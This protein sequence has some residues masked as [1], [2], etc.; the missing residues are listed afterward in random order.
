MVDIEKIKGEIVFTTA[1]SGGPGGQNVN[2][3][4]TKVF[5]H[6]DILQSR[7]LTPEQKEVILKKLAT[8]IQKDGVLQIQVQ[9]TRSQLDN[10][11]LAFEKLTELLQRAFQPVKP[12][13]KTKP[14]KSSKLKRLES[15]K[16]NSEKKK[17]RS[18]S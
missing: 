7:V 6:L 5:L 14:S 15:K 1:R 2:K 16:R 3:L 13:K 12:R 18:G 8:R 10:K 17:W 11:A 9:E 4:N